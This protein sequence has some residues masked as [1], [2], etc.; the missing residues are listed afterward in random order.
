M[1]QLESAQK[2][3]EG[4]EAVKLAFVKLGWG[5]VGVPREYDLGTDLLLLVRDERRFDP[6]LVLGAQIKS[7][8]TAFD[9]PRK[10]DAGEVIGWWF[11]DDDRQHMD[12]WL[13]HSIPHV[14][15]LHHLTTGVSY[16][17]AVTPTSVE[18]TGRGAKMF[19]P[20]GNTIDTDHR[21]ALLSVAATVRTPPVWE[22]S[23]WSGA[24]DVTPADLLRY[25][26]L[27]P[28]LVAPH[29]NSELS[30]PVRPEQVL[31]LVVEA[32]LNEVE[33]FRLKYPAEV[34][35]TVPILSILLVSCGFGIGS[36]SSTVFVDH[37]AKDPVAA[38]RGVEPDDDSRGRGWVDAA[39]GPGADGDH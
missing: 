30:H 7:G 23:V 26:L 34:A 21:D 16:W 12:Y 39:R 17:A 8:D 36:G 10:N 19:V 5:A 25:A 32:R 35:Y 9:E 11:R 13:D 29:R 14:I 27:V 3:A 1:R 22:G 38:D 15:V 6:G 24:S 20:I 18:S 4:E 31:G 2:G 28:R 33:L 37:S